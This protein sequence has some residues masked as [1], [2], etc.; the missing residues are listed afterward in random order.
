MLAIHTHFQ[1]RVF[2]E[3]LEIFED[4]DEPVTN[5][6]LSRMTFLDLVIKEAMRHFPIAPYLGR[7]CTEDFAIHGGII[8]KGTQLFLNVLKANKNPK[9][10]GPNAHEFDPERFLPENCADWHPYQY[11]PFSA[12]KRNCIGERYAWSSL[13]IAMSYLIRRFRFTTDLKM[14]E[15][16]IKPELL[17]KIGNENAVRIERRV[18]RNTNSTN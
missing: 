7:E 2:D 15:V 12:G 17:L 13:K 3:M 1:D 6:H 8:P 5:E 9:F 10:W 18:W 14:H 4:V 16:Q 11:I